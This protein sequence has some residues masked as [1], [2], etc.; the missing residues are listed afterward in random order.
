MSRMYAYS[1]PWR[2]VL[3]GVCVG[4]KGQGLKSTYFTKSSHVL[5]CW[6]VDVTEKL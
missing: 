3:L 6:S 2:P 4:Q 1:L 5:Y